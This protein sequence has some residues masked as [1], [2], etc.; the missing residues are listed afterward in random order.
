MARKRMT[1]LFPFLYPLR[2]AQ[3]KFCF[4]TRMRLDSNR[5]A[6]IHSRQALP[7][8]VF[9]A[10]F[11]LDSQGGGYGKAHN[12]RLAARPVDGIVIR[13]GETFSLWRLIR[14]ADRHEAYCDGPCL[15]DGKLVN[16]PGGG[17]CLLSA[18]LYWAFLHTPLQI[19]ERHPHD[20]KAYPQPGIP[21]GA[22]AAVSEG[23]L[24][25]KIY[26]ATLFTYHVALHADL[27]A[28]HVS[29]TVDTPQMHRYTPDVCAVCQQQTGDDT[30]QMYDVYRVMTDVRTGRQVDRTYV[31]S[32]CYRLTCAP[33]PCRPRPD[34]RLFGNVPAEGIRAVP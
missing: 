11:P 31:L 30:F 23:W 7:H 34:N 19:I 9:C 8:Q 3:R 32:D 13:P 16:R 5:Y 24:D 25:L 17:L 4:Y 21:L 18:L 27:F 29:L 33:V 2:K 10:A 12:V 22:D 26:N 15:V 1:Q 20:F 14:H 28:L 6:H